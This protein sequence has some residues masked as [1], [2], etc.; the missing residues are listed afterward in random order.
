MAIAHELVIKIR[1]QCDTHIIILNK[2]LCVHTYIFFWTIL[3]K[4]GLKPWRIILITLLLMIAAIVR[5]K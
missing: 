3:I 5:Q 1:T 2:P 4:N